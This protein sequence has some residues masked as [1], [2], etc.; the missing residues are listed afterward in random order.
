MR[1]LVVYCHP[2]KSSFCA[3]LH[4]AVIETLTQGKH[5]IID[6]DLYAEGFNP[7]FNI[8]DRANY[9]KPGYVDRVQKYARQLEAAEAIVLV[10]PTWWY[11]MP[12]LLKGYFDRVWAPGIAY[13]VK[14]GGK[15]DTSRLSHIRRIAV[16][17][18]YGSSWWLVRLYMGDP[19]RK[20]ISRGVRHLCGP[21]CALDWLVHYDMDKDTPKPERLARFLEH[22]KSQLRA[23]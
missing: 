8:D 21:R 6:L 7:I 13:D 5:E 14:R 18:T 2:D 3:S 20:V 1:V 9:G 12:A 16:V 23:W 22:V 4:D 15:L 17:T 10:Y 11:G 19:A